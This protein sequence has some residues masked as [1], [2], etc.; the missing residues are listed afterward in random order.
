[1]SYQDY[2]QQDSQFGVDEGAKSGIHKNQA[3]TH[4]RVVS[5]SFRQL[6]FD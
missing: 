1:M 3:S 5:E 2:F 6:E 4:E